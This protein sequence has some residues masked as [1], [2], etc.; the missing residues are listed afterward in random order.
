M[1]LP[2]T[3]VALPA[4]RTVWPVAGTASPAALR[5]E[6]TQKIKAVRAHGGGMVIAIRAVAKGKIGYRNERL[7]HF[8]VAP[9]RKRA[10]RTRAV[11]ITGPEDPSTDG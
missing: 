7:V 3:G 9:V 4:T 8:G 2:D 11:V 5:Q 10:A 6:L 1:A